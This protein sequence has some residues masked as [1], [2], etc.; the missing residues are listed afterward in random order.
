MI[1]PQEI[2]KL[3]TRYAGQYTSLDFTIGIRNTINGPELF[4]TQF[5]AVAKTMSGVPYLI[6]VQKTVFV[7][8]NGDDATGHT[9]SFDRPYKTIQT[10]VLNIGPD[11]ENWCVIVYP[12]RYLGDFTVPDNL[13]MYFYGGANITGDITLGNNTNLQFDS[14]STVTGDITDNG[15]AVVAS[16][17]GCLVL[18][19][20]VEITNGAS[21]V[22]I[23]GD[24]FMGANISGT[25][26]CYFKNLKQDGASTLTVNASGNLNIYGLI[27]LPFN[28]ANLITFDGTSLNMYNC[29]FTISAWVG[30]GH[31]VIANQGAVYLNECE[32]ESPFACV[33]LGASGT[34]EM[35][36]CRATCGTPMAASLGS[37]QSIYFRKCYFN[38]NYGAAPNVDVIRVD[39][40]NALVI[41][42]TT[43]IA[44]G[45]GEC[46]VGLN[47]TTITT[48]LGCASNAN[49][50][51]N[52][53]ETVSTVFVN[54]AYV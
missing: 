49:V 13:N 18:E 5:S 31:C 21:V 39:S 2:N 24:M 7:M 8:D 15:V 35:I 45:T 42:N 14:G 38:V 52:I 51:V 30:G 16:I 33:D 54:P 53:T 47:P 27:A 25:F 50:N 40:T 29:I 43:M 28:Y 44:K 9:E 36:N 20:I 4:K 34:V 1:T 26:N 11:P 10:A 37:T 3:P 22:T 12:G 32:L 46:I 6:N 41:E 19:G 17:C 48:L 23:G